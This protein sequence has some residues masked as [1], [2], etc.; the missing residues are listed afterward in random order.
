MVEETHDLPKGSIG[1]FGTGINEQW[2]G[3]HAELVSASPEILNQ[4][5]DDIFNRFFD[6]PG[7]FRILIFEF[8]IYNRG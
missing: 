4:V 5:Q 3:C 1:I 6:D 8:R 7:F 2:I